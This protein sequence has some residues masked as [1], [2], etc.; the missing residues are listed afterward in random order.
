M[1]LFG[2]KK[3][4]DDQFKVALAKAAAK[5]ESRPERVWQPPPPEFVE[6]GTIHYANLTQ[7]RRHGKYQAALDLASETG[8]PIFANFVEWPG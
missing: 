8:R 2:K 4:K 5:N 3:K 6:L 1:D 7:D